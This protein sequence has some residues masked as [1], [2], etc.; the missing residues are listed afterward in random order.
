MTDFAKR[1]LRCSYNGGRIVRHDIDCQHRDEHEQRPSEAQTDFPDTAQ[2]VVCLETGRGR[3]PVCGGC[4]Q[5]AG[6]ILKTEVTPDGD[7]VP[8]DDRRP[9]DARYVPRIGDLVDVLT[10]NLWPGTKRE[11]IARI[12]Q[13]DGMQDTVCLVYDDHAEF[14]ELWTAAKNVRPAQRRNE[15]TAD[16]MSCAFVDGYNLGYNDSGQRRPYDPES[17]NARRPF[18][19]ERR[20][21]DAQSPFYQARR[22]PE[23]S[24]DANLRGL[25]NNLEERATAAEQTLEEIRIHASGECRHT[26]DER[27]QCFAYIERIAGGGK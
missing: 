5:I 21:L 20:R 16:P 6:D 4:L 26:A 27:M 15:A 13:I 24:T 12:V 19:A 9:A 14:G 22:R 1:H 2:C 10:E 23:A 18:A 17:A 7:K 8:Q 11:W 3:E 25:C